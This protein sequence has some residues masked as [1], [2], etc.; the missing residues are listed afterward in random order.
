MQIIAKDIWLDVEGE[1]S[2]VLYKKTFFKSGA[3]KGKENYVPIGYYSNMRRVWRK[4]EDLGYMEYVNAD[5][6]ACRSFI[7]EAS[8]NVLQLVKGVE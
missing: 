4:I 8:N 1:Y 7:E 6:T 3:N 2:F 5:T